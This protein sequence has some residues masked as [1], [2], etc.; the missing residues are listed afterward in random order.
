MGHEIVYCASC[1]IRLGGLDFENKKAFRVG[2]SVCC[3]KCLDA[4]LAAAP[5]ADVA[6]FHARSAPATPRAAASSVRIRVL[7]EEA[8]APG[9]R[10]WPLGAVAA[11]LV[12]GLALVLLRPAPPPPKTAPEPAPVAR[13]EPPPP[14]EPPKP[15]DPWADL[16]R[17]ARPLEAAEEFRA[18]AAIFENA[19]GQTAGA[20]DRRVADLRRKAEALLPAATERERVARWGYPDLLALFDKRTAPEPP[21]PPPPPPADHKHAELWKAAMRKASARRFAEAIAALEAA[22]VA[23][24]AAL[25][26]DVKALHD[27]GLRVFAS[28]PAGAA[29]SF[30]D[31]S[32]VV[33]RAG[34]RRLELE[35]GEYVEADALSLRALAGLASAKPLATAVAAC[36]D[37]EAA[38]GA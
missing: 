32:G 25:L 2:L 5:P 24:D 14:V 26:K 13:V 35:S 9:R 36:L 8:P 31:V 37:G 23:A 27:E 16:E 10:L 20:V 17:R 1:Q 4:V 11:G 30:G 28:R 33:R 18:A 3:A 38:E 7:K 22:G 29:V 21:P 34:P 12:L 15:A 19:R 6:A